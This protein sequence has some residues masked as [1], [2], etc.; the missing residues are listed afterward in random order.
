VVVD[1]NWDANL[2]EFQ[3]EVVLDIKEEVLDIKEEVLNVKEEVL[4]VKEEDTVD[5]IQRN[6]YREEDVDSL[7]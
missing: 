7:N 2:R 3:V 1:T 6:D 5:M 4:D